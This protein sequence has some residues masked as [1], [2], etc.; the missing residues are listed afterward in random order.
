MEYSKVL[1]ALDDEPKFWIKFIPE[2]RTPVFYIGIE[3]NIVYCVVDS[4]TM[5]RTSLAIAQD[6]GY[7]PSV[8]KL[9]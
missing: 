7:D 5:V 4:G 1:L 3:E 9:N 2:T 6:F 8:M